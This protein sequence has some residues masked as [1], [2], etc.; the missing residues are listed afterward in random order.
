MKTRLLAMVSMILLMLVLF[1]GCTQKSK[2]LSL[3]DQLFSL[4]KDQPYQMEKLPVGS[5]RDVVMEVQGWKD[6][7]LETLS[8][9]ND[10]PQALTLTKPIKDSSLQISVRYGQLWDSDKAVSLMYYLYFPTEES[11]EEFMKDYY[12]YLTEMYS[13]GMITWGS[14]NQKP[15]IGT[16]I[17]ESGK[18]M[19]VKYLGDSKE[20]TM[21][22]LGEDS[23][24]GFLVCISFGTNR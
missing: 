21:A 19:S 24:T 9:E 5:K 8:R 14:E 23:E 17:S 10:D 3:K 6:D 13:D 2:D 12:S 7:D 22:Y 20:Q 15:W 4:S 18:Y 16:D 11:A 1:S